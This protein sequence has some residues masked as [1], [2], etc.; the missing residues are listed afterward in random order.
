MLNGY[1][2]SF[3]VG[4]REPSAILKT[5]VLDADQFPT[6]FSQ[7]VQIDLNVFHYWLAASLEVV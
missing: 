1:D 7:V 3:E 4:D 2:L 5:D 6:F